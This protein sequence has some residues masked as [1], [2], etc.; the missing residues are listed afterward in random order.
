MKSLD[1]LRAL[2]L[3]L[4]FTCTAS[5]TTIALDDWWLQTDNLGGLRQST[6]NE[7]FYFAVSRLGDF[8]AGD[9][10]ETP[11]GFRW[12]T[13]AEGEAAF[14]APDVSGVYVYWNQGGWNGYVW[15][16]V[17]RFLF[18]FSDSYLTLGSKHAGQF[19]EH[20]VQYGGSFSDFAGLVLIRDEAVVTAP[21]SALLLISVLMIWA[22]VRTRPRLG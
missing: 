9:T 10:Y 14:G 19:D 13:T 5:A 8:S 4:A 20:A 16:G 3:W 11:Y 15:D 17:G 7:D 12:A 22:G 18:T 6:W 2:V 21:S 1:C